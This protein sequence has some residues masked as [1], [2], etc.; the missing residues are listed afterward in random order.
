MKAKGGLMWSDLEQAVEKQ[1]PHSIYILV[2]VNETLD[3]PSGSSS[4]NSSTL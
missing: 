3:V 2:K 1:E 4:S